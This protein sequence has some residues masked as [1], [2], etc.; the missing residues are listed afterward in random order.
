MANSEELQTVYA[1]L[2]CEPNKFRTFLTL[3][4]EEGSRFQKFKH[5]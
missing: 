4:R 1:Y 2:N 5:S 3:A